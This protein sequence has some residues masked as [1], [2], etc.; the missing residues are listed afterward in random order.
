MTRRTILTA[1]LVVGFIPTLARAHSIVLTY[2][3]CKAGNLSLSGNFG[4]GQPPQ[5]LI[6]IP[7]QTL[8]GQQTRDMVLAWLM[9]NTTLAATP[10][11]ADAMVIRNLP[12]AAGIT[13][14][15]GTTAADHKIVT[16]AAGGGSV[17]F[18][19]HFEPFGAQLQPAIFTAG[20]VTDV[21]ELA[22]QVSAQELNFQTDGPIICQALFQRL[23]P[24]APQYGATI[25]YAGD[26]LE[27]YFDPA[28]TVTLGGIIIGT[29]SP[30][31][32]A[33]GT[34]TTAP[35]PATQPAV[36]FSFSDAQPGT[37]GFFIEPIDR[38]MV[39]V[40]ELLFPSAW[41]PAQVRDL[42]VQAAGAAGKP[43]L[44]FGPRSMIVPT[45]QPST[46]GVRIG[47]A[48]TEAAVAEPQPQKAII[49]FDNFF[50]PWP[51]PATQPA[52]FA[53]GIVTDVGELTVRIS[54]Q[55][56]NFQTD[57]P[58][59]CQALFQ[60]LA[61]R[62]PQYG[63]QINYAGDRLE[64]YFDPAYTV[65]QGGITFGTTSPSPGCQGIL[66]PIVIPP[67]PTGDINGDGR[68]DGL[69]IQLFLELL[70]DRERFW[71]NHPI[72]DPDQADFDGNGVVDHLDL[73]PFLD[74]VLGRN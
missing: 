56:L 64:V 66:N 72:G 12:P 34:T 60:R 9:A 35:P 57:G 25:N 48:A 32:G 31:P 28:Y 36:R 17:Q 29:T 14:S 61:P 2:A 51:A 7:V 47:S 33:T 50:D 52:V 19:G 53:G 58:I 39:S 5:F 62:A 6:P 20:I 26:R 65:T 24:R 27:V 49:K 16:A 30:T 59:I 68:T 70:T 54:A 21:G 4:P 46:A 69:D 8:S 40:M 37:S 73:A 11:N 23:A 43:A 3:P 13:T 1:V 74:R 55:E 41:Y 71:R 22:V 44:P 42:A 38:Q 18:P 67:A 15:P 63:A 45:S 10:L